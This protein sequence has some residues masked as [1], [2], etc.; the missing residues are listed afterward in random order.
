MQPSVHFVLMLIALI[1]LFCAAINRPASAPI[2]LGWLGMFFWALDILV[3][4]VAR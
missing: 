2:S 3:L 4:G 1:C